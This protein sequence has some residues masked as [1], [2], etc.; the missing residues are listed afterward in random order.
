MGEAIDCDLSWCD[1]HG[2]GKS[3][4]IMAR[5]VR[6]HTNTQAGLTLG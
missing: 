3:S 2:R 6:L 5:P 4:P 1:V